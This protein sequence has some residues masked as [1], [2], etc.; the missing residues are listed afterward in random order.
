MTLAREQ[1]NHAGSGTIYLGMVYSPTSDG[2]W[3]FLPDGALAVNAE[4]NVT[5]VGDSSSVV[6]EFADYRS[7]DHRRCLI[8]P[9]FVDCHQ[10]LCHFEWTR[11]IPDLQEWLEV[12]HDLERRFADLT[13][14]ES[15]ARNFFA[16]M[17][18]NGTTTC[19]VHGP[20]FPE[21][22]DVA[23]RAAAQSGLRVLMGMNAGDRDLAESLSR[24]ADESVGAA[25]ELCATWNGAQGG[26]LSYCFA[27][28]P[29]YCASGVL[30]SA[31][32][33]AATECGGR[34]QSH[35]GEDADGREKMLRLFP[36]CRTEADIYDRAGILGPRTVM[37]HGIHLTDTECALL[38]E[39]GTAIVHCPRANLLSG[40]RQLDLA[41]V[42]G[43]GIR[44]GLGTDLGAGKGLS[45]FRTME[46]ALKV[47]P[48]LSVHEVFRMS[49]LGGAEAL[50]LGERTGSLEPGKDA[51]FLV[52]APKV[53]G[54]VD[55]RCAPPIEDL[56]SCVVFRGDDRNVR[57]A[58][59]RGLP[60]WSETT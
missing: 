27:V 5:A 57:A 20:Y 49:T 39:R 52:L 38:A 41:K 58:Y 55:G 42:L 45:M 13:Y 21:A 35:L 28:R 30:L 34:I 24:P 48:A 19:C 59:V 7:V 17:L 54:A 32:A 26:L 10:H 40:G 51:D 18:R 56:L 43:F 25:I 50:G 15:I 60:V 11:M 1:T 44:V 22:T 4:G 33:K 53:P 46:D 8:T 6:R 31:V 12:I 9:G 16:E 14:A 29:A 3:L 2:N 47:T 36:E 37:A 23:F